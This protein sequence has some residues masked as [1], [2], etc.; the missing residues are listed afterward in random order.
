MSEGAAIA[1]RF[2]VYL[3]LMLLFGLAAYPLYS[4][5]AVCPA[6]SPRPS[7]LR[8]LAILGL[9][10]GAAGFVL[11]TAMMA[12]VPVAGLDR[13]TFVFVVRE[14]GH[15]VSFVVRTAALILAAALLPFGRRASTPWL[16]AAT[17]GIALGSLA[18]TGHAAAT[19]AVL[20]ALHRLS[21]GI[22]LL[23]AGAWLGALAMLLAALGATA[24][25]RAVAAAREALAT[26]AV[27]GSVI[28]GL[29]VLT[30]VVNGLMI[31]GLAGLP[32]LPGTLYGRLLLA[33]LAL[34]ALML[35]LASLNRWRLAPR[36]AAK[37]DGDT[38]RAV[39]VVRTSIAFEIG[40]AIV[41]LALV[42]WL[43]T[44]APPTPM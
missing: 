20:G 31:V 34:F 22:H 10:L 33:K 30:G 5:G 36:L 37:P 44:L 42:A 27:A 40:A 38:K 8:G 35:A 13:E 15:G 41:I 4:G 7:L 18:W 2:G 12:G 17:S 23:T 16:I 43:G 11:M 19:E 32:P 3:D 1:L 14:T 6:A 24:D 9:V 21:D 28:V 29:I 26:F 25:E 39:A